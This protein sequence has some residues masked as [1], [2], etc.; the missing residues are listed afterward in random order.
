MLSSVLIIPWSDAEDHELRSCCMH[1]RTHACVNEWMHLWSL[2]QAEI[3]SE[4]G[5]DLCES[6]EQNWFWP[7][8]H[9]AVPQKDLCNSRMTA[10]P[11]QWSCNPCRKCH[12]SFKEWISKHDQVRLLKSC[13][14]WFHQAFSQKVTFFSNCPCHLITSKET[15][16][17]EHPLTLPC[18][19]EATDGTSLV[20]K[21]Q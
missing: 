13:H 9:E 3:W 16:K 6:N 7:L 15:W 14:K 19:K 20:L 4:L 18:Y 5:E 8:P 17:T 10:R 1:T 21:S 11:S 12:R 2:T